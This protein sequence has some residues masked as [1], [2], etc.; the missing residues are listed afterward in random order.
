[1]QIIHGDNSLSSREHLLAAKQTTAKTGDN[2]VELSGDQIDLTT[3][4]QAVE[5]KS[6]FGP[7]NT[8]FIESLFSQRPSSAK[9]QIIDYL[10]KNTDEKIVTWD[11]KD[12][13]GQLKSFP[14]KIIKRFDLP[15]HIFAF[16]D[17]PALETLHRALQVSPVEQV[18][19]SLATR[20]HKV[21]L[22]QGRFTAKFTITDLKKMNTDL[23]QLEFQ[24][25][26][27]SAPY[28]LQAALEIWLTKL[29]R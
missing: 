19:A 3:L 24:Q 1:M 26:T 2:I 12:I 6:L 25:K 15:K 27:S 28:D 29:V 13:T 18:F 9:K 11:P 8:V 4:V 5:S 14:E 22:G 16:L 7:N 10:L 23:L 21:L 17:S 20:L